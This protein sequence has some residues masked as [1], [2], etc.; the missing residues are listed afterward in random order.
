[1]ATTLTPNLKLIIEDGFTQTSITNLYKI[2]DLGSLFQVD[3]NADARIRSQQDIIIQPHD[4]IIGGNGLGG[5]INLGTVDQ[6]AEIIS[7]NATSLIINAPVSSGTLSTALLN[8]TN[9]GFNLSL[10]A[11]TL[12]ENV[13]LTLPPNDGTIN[14]VLTTDG[15]GNL[16]WSTVAGAGDFG[17]ELTVSW[18]AADGT[19]K[20]I[21]HGFNSQNIIVQV[22]DPNDNFRTVEV[23][24]VTRP[25]LNTVVLDSSIAPTVEW[26]VL[27]KQIT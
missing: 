5:T 22:I 18:A 23:D 25:T 13:S 19:T 2:D 1:M 24:D 3:A 26:T 15:S 7:L 20:T 27:L 16:N 12:T 9:S 11:P 14:Q 6:P 17:S 8:L 4:P 10:Q 21:T